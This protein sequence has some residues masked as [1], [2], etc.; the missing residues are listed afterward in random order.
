M[1]EETFWKIWNS[2]NAAYKLIDETHDLFPRRNPCWPEFNKALDAV[3]ELRVKAEHS[4]LKAVAD[5]R[6]PHPQS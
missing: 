1:T 6:D 5:E 4:F 3:F 2:I